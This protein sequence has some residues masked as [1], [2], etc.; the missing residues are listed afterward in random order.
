MSLRL[1]TMAFVGLFVAGCEPPGPKRCTDEPSGCP[2]G[3]YAVDTP[4]LKTLMGR[5]KLSILDLRSAEDYAAGHIPGAI[6]F[7]PETLSSVVGGVPGQVTPASKLAAAFSAAGVRSGDHVIAYDAENGPPPARL[8][9]TLL[10]YGYASGQVQVLDGG[11]AAW[12]A[13]GEPVETVISTRLGVGRPVT[14]HT[15][16]NARRVDAVWVGAHLKDPKVALVD[17]RS[18]EEYAAGH[19]PGAVNIPWESTREGTRFLSDSG[20]FSLYGDLFKAQTVVAYS[21]SGMRASLLWLTLKMLAHPDVR[22][23]D[24]SWSEWGARE[25]L[26]RVLGPSPN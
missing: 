1:V 7:D 4:A 11:Y 5:G 16:N 18:P 26:P 9:W 19:I 12:T 23:Y 20:L 25:D 6:R 8:V 21:K 24:G 22:I 15:P 14:L 3:V 10:Y 17:A 13:A 2:R